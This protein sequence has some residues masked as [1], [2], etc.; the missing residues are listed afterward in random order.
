MDEAK[1]P[2]IIRLP[3]S[4]TVAAAID[5]AAK[6]VLAEIRAA[7]LPADMQKATADMDSV[8][9]AATIKIGA[10]IESGKKQY[11]FD[12]ACLQSREAKVAAGEEQV[13]KGQAAN[14]N[15]SDQIAVMRRAYN[16]AVAAAK[17]A[18]E[19]KLAGK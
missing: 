19:T 8:I 3:D 5:A 9:D 1:E 18:F 10:T 14:R 11:A 17:K 4:A 12:L 13:A 15:A 7:S 16:N 6:R 2:A